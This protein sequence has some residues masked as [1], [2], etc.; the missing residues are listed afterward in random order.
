MT[1]YL[2]LKQHSKTGLKYFGKTE[3][4]DPYSYLGSGTYWKPHINKHGK[5]FV[6][7]INLW[8]FEDQNKASEFALKFSEENNIVKSKEW[9]NQIPE[10]GINGGG[11]PKGSPSPMQGKNHT[12]ETKTKLSDKALGNKRRLGKHH[13]EETKTKLSERMRG[14]VH[15]EETKLKMSESRKGRFVGEKNPMYGKSPSLDHR[16][17]IAKANTGKI[18][19]D[20]TKAKISESN[21]NRKG[22]KYKSMIC[23]NCG[24]EGSGGSMK[25]FHFDN[26][27]IK[28][29]TLQS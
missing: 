5:E 7:T 2:Y 15:S 11:W 23:P 13:T 14:K 21:R 12:E 4:S 9:A 1:I 8:Q 26:C 3:Q 10:D 28:D 18:R 19:T 22:I 24:K 6:E 20:E 17:K 27:K 16:Q 25:R 29:Q